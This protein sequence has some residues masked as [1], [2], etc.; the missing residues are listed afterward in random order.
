MRA[1]FFCM[2]ILFLL[3][4]IIAFAQEIRSFESDG[5]T[6]FL[7]GNWGHCCFEHD[8]RYWVGGDI[9]EQK[10]SDVKLKY[11]VEKAAGPL[12]ANIIYA[13]V[14]VGHYSPIKHKYKWS[15]G[16]GEPESFKPLSIEERKAAAKKLRDSNLD[17][18]LKDRFIRDELGL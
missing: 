13:A 7:D 2:K 8:L 10:A 3:F 14:R 17:A 9:A 6:M 12:A 1:F 11:C 5:C 16:W 18:E 15:W 4:P